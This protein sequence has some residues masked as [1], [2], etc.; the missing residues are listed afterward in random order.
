MTKLAWSNAQ[1]QFFPHKMKKVIK[2]NTS[3]DTSS[4]LGLEKKV[5]SIA[6]FI[7]TALHHIARNATQGNLRAILGQS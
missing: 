5:S 3:P 4:Q 6:Q 1:W 2:I 7:A